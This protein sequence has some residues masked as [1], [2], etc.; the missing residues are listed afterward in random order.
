MQVQ[1]TEMAI[2][3]PGE[4]PAILIRFM[5]KDGVCNA[6]DYRE[7]Y[8]SGL[9]MDHWRGTLEEFTNALGKVR[10]RKANHPPPVKV[11]KRGK[12]R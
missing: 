8:P 7:F 11:D 12:N 2:G 9:P 10:Q 1:Y 4:T 6:V 3:H 5:H